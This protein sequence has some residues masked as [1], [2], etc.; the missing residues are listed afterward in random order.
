MA[1]SA[2]VYNVTHLTKPM[3]RMMPQDPQTVPKVQDTTE[4]RNSARRVRSRAPDPSGCTGHKS[5]TGVE[6]C[7]WKGPP[8]RLVASALVSC[9][10]GIVCGSLGVIPPMGSVR[11]VGL[12]TI[13]PSPVPFTRTF[14]FT[15][16]GA[17]ATGRVRAP[18]TRQ[19]LLATRSQ[20][21]H[22][23]RA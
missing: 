15:L 22:H 9:N 4:D 10:L 20:I 8:S 7:V 6:G 19:R 1:R 5:Q 18:Q 13:R 11:L 12:H 2:G 23:A 21:T 16:Y 17:S 14:R 3:Q